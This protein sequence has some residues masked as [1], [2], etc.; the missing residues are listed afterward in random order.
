MSILSR[1]RDLLYLAFFIIHIPVLFCVDLA[2]LYPK[3]I[4]PAFLVKLHEYQVKTYA[5]RFF[6]EPPAWFGV[7]IWMEALYHVPLS[8]WAI[9]ALLRSTSS[10]VKHRSMGMLMVFVDDPKVPLHLLVYAVQTVITTATCIADFLSWSDYE[11]Q[12]KV[13][14]MKLYVPYLAL[15]GYALTHFATVTDRNAAVF[16]GV[17]M[18]GRLS[19][20]IDRR[21]LDPRKTK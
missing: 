3:S 14:L 19:Q 18:F 1:K 8:F 11:N 16:M 9:G 4:K 5:D 6:T 13:E 17:D 20:S 10:S 21:R 2:S 15:C 7:Y 12:Q